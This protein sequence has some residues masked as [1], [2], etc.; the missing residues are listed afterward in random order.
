MDICKRLVFKTAEEL[1]LPSVLVIMWFQWGKNVQFAHSMAVFWFSMMTVIFWWIL[2][3]HLNDL[4]FY[5]MSKKNMPSLQCAFLVLGNCVES[6]ITSYLELFWT[7]YFH[8][9]WQNISPYFSRFVKTDRQS[10]HKFTEY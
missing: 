10:I 4:N 6:K 1:I 5:V 3:L 8:F 9:G 2:G 7:K